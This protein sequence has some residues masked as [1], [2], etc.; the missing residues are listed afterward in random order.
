[1]L[2]RKAES[3]DCQWVYEILEELRTPI[4]YSLEQFRAYYLSALNDAHFDFYIFSNGEECIGLI[5]LNKF[6][7]PRYLGYGYEMEEFAVH[8]DYRG[9]GM[10]YLMIE[11]VKQLIVKDKSVRKLIIKSNGAD[12]QHIYSK[13][14][15][16]TDL[17]T[18][19]V[20]L[21]KL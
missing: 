16:E 11:G 18:F 4:T 9:K 3:Q 21:N 10:S 13:A 12:S 15:N 6:N 2:L 7:M 20:Y 5:S 17:T 19:Q 1:M 14:L 8:K